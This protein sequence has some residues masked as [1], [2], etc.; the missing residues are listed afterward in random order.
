MARFGRL[1]RLGQVADFEVVTLVT[2]AH[3]F[4]THASPPA[5]PPPPPPP[6]PSPSEPQPE[7]PPTAGRTSSMRERIV[8]DS[9]GAG[10]AFAPLAGRALSSWAEWRCEAYPDSASGKFEESRWWE[11]AGREEA[12]EERCLVTAG[13]AQLWP[14]AGGPSGSGLAGVAAGSAGPIEISAGDWV[15]FKRGFL[16]MGGD[17]TDRQALCLL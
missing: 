12:E 9:R 7:L 4:P 1:P 10:A 6:A 3:A 15:V 5:P 14:R 2:T 11:A 8:V 13:R 16:H 17:R